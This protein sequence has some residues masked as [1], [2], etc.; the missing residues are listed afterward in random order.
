MRVSVIARGGWRRSPAFRASLLSML[1]SSAISSAQTRP[2]AHAKR[3]PRQIK[4]REQ[5]ERG[6]R[7]RP[8]SPVFMAEGGGPAG[9]DR[10]DVLVYATG[11]DA[12]AYMR[13]M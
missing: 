8:C 1:V 3:P 6:E 9:A 4:H 10:L 2:P 12:H 7:L 11:F 5:K 13:P